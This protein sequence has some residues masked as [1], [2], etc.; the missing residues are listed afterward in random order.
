LDCG[1]GFFVQGWASATDRILAE[2][3]KLSMKATRSRRAPFPA[4]LAIL[5]AAL[6]FLV[7]ALSLEAGDIRINGRLS[8]EIRANGDVYQ[9]GRRVGEIRQDGAV[10]EGGRRVGELRANG[11]VYHGGRRVG[12]IRD[13]GDVYQA[14]RRVGEIRD[15]GD[16][17]QGG[18]RVGDAKA[19]PR[20]RAVAVFFFFGFLP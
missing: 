8:G 12:E 9:G 3:L 18:R 5:A 17:Y 2:G 1:A 14:G 20:G 6:P 4:R 16:I 19:V 10:Y 15:N 11:H 13:N 7:A